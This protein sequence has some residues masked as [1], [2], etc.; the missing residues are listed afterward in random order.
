MFRD[1]QEAY[2]EYVSTEQRGYFY[3]RLHVHEEYLTAVKNSYSK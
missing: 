2:S 1:L 3:K